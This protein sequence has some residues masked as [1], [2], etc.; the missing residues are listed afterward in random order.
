MPPKSIDEALRADFDRVSHARVYFGHQSVGA[1]IMDGLA[2]LQRQIGQ[3]VIR[4]GD[5]DSIG[6]STDKGILLHTKIGENQKPDSK[7]EDFPAD[8][9]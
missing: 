7:C 6:L 3:P 9:G 5:L 1:N 4:I 8:P 2:D